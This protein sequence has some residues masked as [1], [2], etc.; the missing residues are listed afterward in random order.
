MMND[1]RLS[2]EIRTRWGKPLF[3]LGFSGWQEFICMLW[4]VEFRIKWGY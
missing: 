1:K 3:A 4:I 2:F